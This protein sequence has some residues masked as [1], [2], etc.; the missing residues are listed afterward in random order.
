MQDSEKH[1]SYDRSEPGAADR[2]QLPSTNDDDALAAYADDML[3]DARPHNKTPLA[4]LLGLAGGIVS[5]LIPLVVTLA[6]WGSTRLV[7]VKATICP[8][9]WHG[10]LQGYFA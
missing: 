9:I 7:P 3:T 1:N 4:L 6:N 5:A 8:P 2:L 10:P